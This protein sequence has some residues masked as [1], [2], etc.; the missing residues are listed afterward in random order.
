MGAQRYGNKAFAKWHEKLVRELEPLVLKL[1]DEQT[2]PALVEITPYLVDSF[3]NATRI[4][5]GTGHEAAFIIFLLCP[6]K[7]GHLTP[8]D[9]AAIVLRGFHRYLKLVRKLQ[10]D[11]RMEPAGSRGVHAL[12]DFQFCTYIFGSSQLISESDFFNSNLF[13]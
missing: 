3:G 8:E 7:L 1:L 4:D 12:D 6:Y 9:D 10:T 2:K 11:Y 5:Y 13:F